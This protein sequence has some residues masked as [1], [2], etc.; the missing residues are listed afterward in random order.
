MEFVL[1]MPMLLL[2]IF[3]IVQFALIWYAQ[4][5]THYAAYNAARAALVY[6]P[7]EYCVTDEKG[8]VT[9][10]FSTTN[11]VCWEAA[12]RT[13]AWVSNSPEGGASGL[14]IPGW[15]PEGEGYKPIPYSSH[16]QNQ[17]RIVKEES[18]ELTNAP[19]VKVSV[20]FDFPLCVPVIGRMLA[21]FTHIEETRPSHWEVSG[22]SPDSAGY[23]ELDTFLH[24]TMQLDYITLKG[25]MLLPKPWSSRRFARCPRKEA[26]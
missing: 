3:A 24:P 5:M 14:G 9:D 20:E 11:G 4:I 16:I 13:L 18:L 6:H 8:I 10:E 25:T 17:V 22:W 15:W 12:C 1:V 21:Y 19:A 26:P 7:G 2:F 23:A